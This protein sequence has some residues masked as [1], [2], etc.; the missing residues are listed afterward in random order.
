LNWDKEIA[1]LGPR[2]KR[3]FGASVPGHF[4]SDLVQE[5]FLRLVEK[6]QD[7]TFDPA[8]GSVRM[9]AFGI[10][11]NIRQETWRL[12][13]H[14]HLLLPDVAKSNVCDQSKSSQEHAEENE[15][16]VILRKA[17][18]RLSGIEQ[19][20]VLLMLDKDL[21][22]SEIGAVLAIPVGTVKSHVHRAKV[23][24]KEILS[25]EGAS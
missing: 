11:H 23:S 14:D 16:A 6:Y 25:K 8:R 21:T 9:F 1:D 22:M 7:G 19:D 4:A 18:L 13:S 17:I 3:Y 15:L 20:I 5:V 2:L 24:L 10:A 12:L